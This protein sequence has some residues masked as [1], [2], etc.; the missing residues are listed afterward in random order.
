MSWSIYHGNNEQWNHDIL[1]EKKSN[2]FHSSNWSR[3][4][5]RL[6]WRSCKF[7]KKIDE[8]SHVYAQCFSKTYFGIFTV[9]WFPDWLAGDY[10]H[11][12]ELLDF[13][14][15][16]LNLKIFYIRVRSHN[17]KNEYETEILLS[18]FSKVKRPIDS[19]LTMIVDLT[20]EEQSIEMLQSK[21]W[22]RN[23]KR[24]SRVQ[25]TIE[26]VKDISIVNDLYDDLALIKNKGK[27]LSG[28]EIKSISESFLNNIILI[29]AKSPDGKFHAIR[30]ALTFGDQATDIFAAADVYARNNYLSYALCWNLLKHARRNGCKTYDLNGVDPN[31]MGVYNFKKGIGGELVE[32]NG[33]FEYSNLKVY[34][35]MINIFLKY[36]K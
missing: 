5:E 22:R 14:K 29:G 31:N 13:I 3:H 28:D 21:N 27:F 7:V 10:I 12:K 1:H 26:Q 35:K 15:K 36:L 33:E 25:Y 24:S 9:I 32:K 17:I 2:Y 16:Y 8:S 18:L 6:G 34:R 30:G 20:P 19:N 11:G 4:L 23:L